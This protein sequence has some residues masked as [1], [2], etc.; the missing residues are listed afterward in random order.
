M[1]QLEIPFRQWLPDQPDLNNPG[2]VEAKNVMRVNGAYQPVGGIE[3]PGGSSSRSL[4]LLD[5]DEVNIAHSFF[6]ELTV[7]SFLVDDAGT[8]KLITIE[9]NSGTKRE[10]TITGASDC[11]FATF[12]DGEYYIN[13]TG[14]VYQ[15]LGNAAFTSVGTGAMTTPECLA[16][17][18]N[19]LMAGKLGTIQWS[20]FNAPEDWATSELTQAGTADV[21]YPELGL[22]TNIIGGRTNYIFQMHGVS[23]LTYV[24]PPKIWDVRVISREAGAIKNT[25]IEIEGF[26]YF[27]GGITT[28]TA[29]YDGREPFAV[30]KTNGQG[31]SRISFQKIESWLATNFDTAQSTFSRQVI[32]HGETRNIIWASGTGE[33]THNY[34]CLN[35]DTDEFSYFQGDYRILIPGPYR[36]T[37]D[38]KEIFAVAE[39]ASA[40]HYGPLS[41]DNLEATLTTGHI[42]NAGSRAFVD[43]V[44][45]QYIGSGSTVALSAKG[46]LRD[47]TSFSS[48]VAEDATTGIADV[49]AD[50]RAVALSVKY[51]AASSW[52]EFTGVVADASKAGER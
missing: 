50:G 6:D 22:V 32:W 5:T 10:T 51:P 36:G 29:S 16:R 20:G 39:N 42:A 13:N 28:A 25:A 48:Y 44:E 4:G 14:V 46:R 26:A 37:G 52:S 45:P 17:V 1:P 24:G 21:E 27:I 8:T 3:F 7:Y 43:Q 38:S 40:L 31:V 2:L 15:A 49:T 30:Y 11:N 23:R 47:A 12:G 19:F 35:V 9:P 33:G 34:L 18:G 41:G